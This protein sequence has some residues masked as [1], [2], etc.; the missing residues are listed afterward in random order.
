MLFWCYNNKMLRQ[1]FEILKK[2]FFLSLNYRFN[3][4]FQFFAWAFHLFL[5]YF[6]SKIIPEKN[7]NETRGYFPFV[8]SGI[9][10]QSL[11]NS[12]LYG[13]QGRIRE[14]MLMGNLEFLL[15]IL[16]KPYIFLISGLIYDFFNSFL[17]I[18]IIIIGANILFSFPLQNFNPILFFL[19]LLLSAISFSAI[20]N[21]SSAFVLIFRKGEPFS[22][23]F[24][25]FSAF[26]GGIFFP[27]SLFPLFLQKICYLLPITHGLLLFRSSFFKIEAPFPI[28]YSFIY[29]FVF[30]LFFY[31][32]SLH[33]FSKAFVYAKRK[34]TISSY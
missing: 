11:L 2:D 6:L 21:F 26:L 25:M 29:F 31:T 14:H 33:T 34:G 9:C 4:F 15:N 1:V 10:L 16:K 13:N 20:G 23:F 12:I 8:L 7:F 24:T 22:N 18:L 17:R 30:I 19:S 5:W 27:V 28:S 3:F 32:L